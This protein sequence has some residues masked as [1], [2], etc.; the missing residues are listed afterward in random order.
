MAS[1]NDQHALSSPRTTSRRPTGR[2]RARILSGERRR[3]AAADRASRR[4]IGR[5]GDAR[6]RRSSTSGL[7]DATRSRRARGATCRQIPRFSTSSEISSLL[8]AI[9]A[10]VTVPQCTLGKNKRAVAAPWRL[11]EPPY[12]HLPARRWRRLARSGAYQRPRLIHRDHR[13]TVRR[14]VMQITMT[15]QARHYGVSLCVRAAGLVVRF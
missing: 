3:A 2:A 15:W 10:P 4:A 7:G 6:A 9:L 13:N 12:R 14:Y 5:D 1:R 11:G 8:S